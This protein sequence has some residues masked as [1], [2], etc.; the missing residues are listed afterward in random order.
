[1]GIGSMMANEYLCIRCIKVETHVA[2]NAG[3][4]RFVQSCIYTV[5]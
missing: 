3:L 5:P 4:Q 2:A 1:M